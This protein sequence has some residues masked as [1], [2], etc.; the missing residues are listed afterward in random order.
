MR[1]AM[2]LPS[3]A[4]GFAPP[5]MLPLD[6]ERRSVA[7]AQLLASIGLAAGTLI[8]A[9]VITAGI[10]RA[11]GLVPMPGQHTSIV[12]VAVMVGVL[13]AGMGGLTAMSLA[14]SRRRPRRD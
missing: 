13:F 5:P 8:A 3:H 4:T 14:P 11:D 9:T 2:R 7:L 6:R 10:A 1:F 12:A